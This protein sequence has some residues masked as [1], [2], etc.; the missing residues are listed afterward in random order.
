MIEQLAKEAFANI[1][2]Q[3]ANFKQ[4]SDIPESQLR[5]ILE[6]A[7]RKFNLVSREEFDAQAA[8]LMRTREKLDALEL[9]LAELVEK[10]T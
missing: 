2:A 7:I 9:Q 10:S 3:A 1:Q 4:A 5:A 8:V 6:A